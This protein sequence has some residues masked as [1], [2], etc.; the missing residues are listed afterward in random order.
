VSNGENYAFDPSMGRKHSFLRPRIITKGPEGQLELR[1]FVSAIVKEIRAMSIAASFVRQTILFFLVLM[2]SSTLVGFQQGLAAETPSARQATPDP[3]P[4]TQ[5]EDDTFPV[6]I[7][8]SDGVTLEIS[9]RPERIVSLS[10]GGTELFFA[11]GAGDQLVA[12]DMFSDYPEEANALPK[13]D[14]F[15]PDPEAILTHNPDL[16]L[17]TYDA[18]GIVSA[19]EQAGVPVLFL[20][21]PESIDG[22]LEQA[23]QFGEI[24]GNREAAEELVA[25]MEERIAAI[26][27]KLAKVE[28][29]PRV[30]HELDETFFTVGPDSFVGDLYNLLNAQNIAAGAPGGYP[31]L[32]AEAIIERNPEVIILPTG[33]GEDGTTPEDVKARPGWDVIDA[34]QNDR[35]YEIDRD[36]V[37]RPGPRII[38]G[39]EQLAGLLYPET[40]AISQPLLIV[41]QETFVSSRNVFTASDDQHI[42]A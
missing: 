39:L 2:L 34:V 22:L 28:E 11:V 36:I 4:V 9:E 20:D 42:A 33:E 41:R 25:G 31:Q 14:A 13:V 40:F 19:L 10:A 18:D 23:R 5:A 38:D 17:V 30:Y 1:G 32:S 35:V 12:A 26:T 27:S 3:S 8:R 15:Q 16:V 24:T 29:G 6:S 37:S 21:V 7:T